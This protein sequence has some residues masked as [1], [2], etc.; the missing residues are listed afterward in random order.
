MKFEGHVPYVNGFL[1]TCN[2][3]QCSAQALPVA[4]YTSAD[5]SRAYSFVASSQVGRKGDRTRSTF[6]RSSE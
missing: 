3:A 5:E 2:A 6:N 1:I 4:V